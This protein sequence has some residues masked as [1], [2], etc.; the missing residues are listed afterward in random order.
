V[1]LLC[2]SNVTGDGLD[3]LRALLG[4]LTAAGIVLLLRCY[5]T[6]YII[7]ATCRAITLCY[8]LEVHSCRTCYK[9][10]SNSVVNCTT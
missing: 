10:L 2:V 5:Y 3:V 6:Q 7:T 1:P 9:R 4:Q 8:E